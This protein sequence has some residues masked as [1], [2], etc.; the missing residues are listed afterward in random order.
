VTPPQ[1]GKKSVF[2]DAF[3]PETLFRQEESTTSKTKGITVISK[4]V[5][6]FCAT[7]GVVASGFAL[8][9]PAH[10]EPVSLSYAVVGS[11]TL[12][13]VVGALI[14]GTK[15]TGTKVQSI[16]NNMASA[17]YDASGSQ[18]IMTRGNLPLAESLGRMGRPN[19]SGDGR[20]AL[21]ASINAAGTETFTPSGQLDRTGTLSVNSTVTAQTITGYV[22]IARASSAGK[23]S[24]G[25]LNMTQ[26]PFGRD[27]LGYV[28]NA[29][30]TATGIENLTAAELLTIFTGGDVTKNGIVIRAVTPQVGSGTGKDWAVM[31]G[32]SDTPAAVAL[33]VTNLKNTYGQEHDASNLPV[34]VIAPMSATRWIAM[35]T[36]A[37]FPKKKQ[38]ILFG[39]INGVS[40]VLNECT[41]GNFGAVADA[42]AYEKCATV[43]PNPA[44]YYSG[45]TFGGNANPALGTKKF[46]R[47]TYVVV[48]TARVT[49]GNA[50]Y[51]SALASLFVDENSFAL[52]NYQA[53]TTKAGGVKIKFGFLEALSHTSSAITKG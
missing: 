6:A 28:Y 45:E 44:F 25:T 52:T 27:A 9:M 31:I 7:F 33:S 23:T 18:Y 38:N 35:S 48:E 1:L 36:G 21:Y 51:D 5:V 10:A 30:S 47:D 49:S 8:A 24:G 13:D 41:T 40:P 43:A 2:P 32:N 39:Q 20:S 37:S 4:K 17:S 34:N 19:G 26:Y 22:D 50:K 3:S 12:E 16:A 11:D 53:G 42:T 46:G 14:N 15:I 29:N